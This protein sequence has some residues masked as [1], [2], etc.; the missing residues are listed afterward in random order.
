[1]EDIVRRRTNEKVLEVCEK[2]NEKE[3]NK[4]IQRKKSQFKH[5]RKEK[6]V[7]HCHTNSER[8]TECLFQ[9]ATYTI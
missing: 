8:Y 4:R 3:K 9:F 5:Y 1:M 2:V 6:N 7:C